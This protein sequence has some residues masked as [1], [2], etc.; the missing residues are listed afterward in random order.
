M[1]SAISKPA[2]RAGLSVVCAIIL[3]FF[4]TQI[5]IL[6]RFA[7]PVRIGIIVGIAIIGIG[8][9]WAILSPEDEPVVPGEKLYTADEV[10]QL[11]AAVQAGRLVPVEPA[12][13]K[14]CGGPKPDASGIDGTRYHVRCFQAAYQVGKT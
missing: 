7:L 2:M 1:G 13:C 8:G 9:I 11:L 4:A 6:H 3:T 10:A 14:Y 5:Y 12:V